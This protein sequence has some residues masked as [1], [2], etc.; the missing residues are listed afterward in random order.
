MKPYYENEN[1][2]LYLGKCE[3]I[4]PELEKV[5]LVLTDPPYDIETSGGGIYN[6][7][8]KQYV[9]ELKDIKDGFS[10]DILKLIGQGVKKVNLYI[11]CSQKQL[12]NLLNFFVT[13]R[14]YNYNILSWHKNNPGPA[15]G[16]KYLTDTEYILFFREKGVKLYGT[17]KT[18]K[19]FFV[20]EL[21][22]S[23]KR[24]YNHPTIKPTGIIRELIINSTIENNIVLDPFFGS[25]STGVA[26]E[27]LDRKWIGIEKEEKYCEISAKRIEAENKQLKMF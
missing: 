19:T 3:E 4:M 20:T 18:K 12:I 25:G 9:K 22:Q 11:F 26:C 27:D 16:N 2:K 13:C 15:C 14:G 7:E 5:D 1:G 21:N 23:D 8:D 17:Y 10:D 24:K 6:Q